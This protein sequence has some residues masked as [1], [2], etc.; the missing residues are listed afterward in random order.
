[1]LRTWNSSGNRSEEQLRKNLEL[2]IFCLASAL[3]QK[4][5]TYVSFCSG[6]EVRRKILNQ[7]F[8]FYGE[9]ACQHNSK[10]KFIP[11]VKIPQFQK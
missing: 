9:A 5:V 4:L 10:C 7:D 3:E 11:S 6:A 2:K 8:S 1:M